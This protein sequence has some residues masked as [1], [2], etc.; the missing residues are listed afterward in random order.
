MKQKVNDEIAQF[1][2]SWQK[3]E[4]D[5]NGLESSLFILVDDL[6]YLDKQT[7]EFESYQEISM[8]LDELFTKASSGSVSK[9][10]VEKLR[11]SRAY[12]SRVLQKASQEILTPEIV[13][14]R[15][16]PF[17]ILAITRLEEIV[18]EIR[19]NQEL[20]GD[21]LLSRLQAPVEAKDAPGYISA[22][23]KEILQ[24]VPNWIKPNN[25]TWETLEISSERAW[26]NIVSFN[27]SK[28]CHSLLVNTSRNRTYSSWECKA[29]A[30]HEVCGHILHLT[31][32]RDSL[33]QNKNAELAI[34]IHTVDSYYT[35]TV[36]QTL[37]YYIAKVL[38]EPEL[39]YLFYKFHL[40]FSLRNNALITA[41]N[42]SCSSDCA[43]HYH[44]NFLE[45][46]KFT[47]VDINL[48]SLAYKKILSDPFFC[49]QTFNYVAGVELV[50][51]YLFK[52]E[53]VDMQII[54]FLLT[55]PRS[56]SD[57]KNFLYTKF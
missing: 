5:T 43:V 32:L 40:E 28:N 16:A 25:I 50:I 52:N 23:A 9:Y 2:R 7:I 22:F 53:D 42:N 48:L 37:F 13:I 55:E 15:G 51:P 49:A 11:N 14:Q 36:A 56:H 33:G 41:I 29:L 35:E 21:H 17:E 27:K 19:S 24:K 34:S 4:A 10:L 57:V 39:L 20:L 1:Y 3:F 18:D 54:N 38:D 8:K 44:S 46:M 6:T 31:K 47:E 26:R 30:I 45:N 12:L